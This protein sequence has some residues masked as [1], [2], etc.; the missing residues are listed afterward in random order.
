[1][2]LC[3][4][5]LNAES[6]PDTSTESSLNGIKEAKVAKELPDTSHD[7]ASELEGLEGIRE[8]RRSSPRRLINVQNKITRM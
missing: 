3:V 4:L 6:E 1:M 8:V 7:K 5:I 2:V